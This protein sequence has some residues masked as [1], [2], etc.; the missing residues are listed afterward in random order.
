MII[1]N[2]ILKPHILQ[3]KLPQLKVKLDFH[4]LGPHWS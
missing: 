2:I 1:D 3:L 4:A